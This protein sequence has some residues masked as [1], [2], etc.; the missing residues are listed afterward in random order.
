MRQRQ[1]QRLDDRAN[2]NC[3]SLDGALAVV[4]LAA[5][6]EPVVATV[7]R[8]PA[9]SRQQDRRP[10]PLRPEPASWI[11]ACSCTISSSPAGAGWR[12]FDRLRLVEASACKAATTTPRAEPKARD[13][14][15]SLRHQRGNGADPEAPPVASSEAR[16]R[17]HMHEFDSVPASLGSGLRHPDWRA[18]W[19]AP[20][21]TRHKRRC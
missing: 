14:R 21:M 1:R 19:R 17:L 18:H 3:R 20:L 8:R 11:G 5:E 4:E 7:G 16:V 15:R 2:A 13:T 6:R 10:S 9:G 12:C